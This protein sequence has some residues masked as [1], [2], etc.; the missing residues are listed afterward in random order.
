MK[1]FKYNNICLYKLKEKIERERENILKVSLIFYS[2]IKINSILSGLKNYI[3]VEIE[4]RGIYVINRAEDHL[5]FSIKI[6]KKFGIVVMQCKLSK[7]VLDNKI[8][9]RYL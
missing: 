9:F 4:W 8:F 2:I 3:I 1:C 5:N 6:N 7:I